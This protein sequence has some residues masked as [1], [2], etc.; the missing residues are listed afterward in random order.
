MHS[1]MEQIT[2]INGHALPSFACSTELWNFPW[3]AFFNRSEGRR[4]HSKSLRISGFSLKFGGMMHSNMKQ[5]VI[6]SGHAWP[7]FVHSTELLN[8]QNRLGLGPR[9]NVTAL[10]LLGFQLSAWNLGD[11]AQYDEADRY[12][13]WPCSAN[14]CTFHGTVKYPE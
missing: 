9:D 7:I 5:I 2:I 1:T 10:T 4:Y 13:K 8:F 14:F 12:L 6:Q 11:D 3:Q